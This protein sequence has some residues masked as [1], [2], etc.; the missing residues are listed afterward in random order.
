MLSIAWRG[1]SSHVQH[2]DGVFFQSVDHFFHS[3]DNSFA[4]GFDIF[5]VR[6]NLHDIHEEIFVSLVFFFSW[7]LSDTLGGVGHKGF[8]IFKG[9][10][11]LGDQKLGVNRGPG[12][13]FGVQCGLKGLN[14]DFKPGDIH[15]GGNFGNFNLNDF[16][17]LDF[18]VKKFQIGDFGSDSIQKGV[19]PLNVF[20]LALSSF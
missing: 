6:N 15:G 19:F 11:E 9:G 14:V 4:F 7:V 17:G 12:S 10:F 20:L 5:D 2:V 8:K 3:F 13:D 1:S 16:E 18:F